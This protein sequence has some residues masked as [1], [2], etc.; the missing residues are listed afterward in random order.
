M[1]SIKA[2]VKGSALAL[3]TL[4]SGLS[5]ADGYE[6]PVNSWLADSPWP[7]SHRTSYAQG[8]SPL[9][10]PEEWWQVKPADYTGTSLTNI[11]LA[12]SPRYP[13]GQQVYWGST[14]GKVYKLA[15]NTR[16]L[17]KYSQI[18][19]P[20][21]PSLDSLRTATSGAYT[22]VDRDNHFYT[23]SG[24]S[25]LVYKDGS[26][27]EARSEIVLDREYLIPASQLRGDI[28]D[29]PIVGMNLTYD[30]YVAF[31]TK[32]GTVGVVDR[33]FSEAHFVQLGDAQ[34]EEI[35]NS[36]ALDEEGGIYVVSAKKMYR[37]QWTGTELTLDESKGGWESDY[38]TG[39]DS[40]GGGRLGAGS[41]STPSLMG[42][43]G[44]DKFV[45][46]TDG[47]PQTHLVLLWRDEIPAD[48][49][50]IAP[51]KS[52]RIAAEVPVNYGDAN[53]TQSEQSV[54]VRG[55]GAVVVSNDYRNVELLSGQS[56]GND[57]I[58]N[59]SNGLTVFLSAR[60]LVQP[61]GVQKFEWN[62]ASRT[63]DSVW[64]RGDISCPNGIPTMSAQSQLFYCIG[65]RHGAWTLEALR[66]H[67]GSSKFYRIIGW[68]NIYN[69][70][71]AATQIGSDGRIVSGTTLGVMELD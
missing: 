41:G 13:D 58:D 5:F 45:V 61:Y 49:Q 29:D 2:V 39:D 25:V 6:P 18:N 64:T 62:P 1:K 30:G 24:S 11:T 66:W 9:R 70:F 46:I 63:L 51:G 36:I 22:F 4:V 60:P 65:A 23:V 17:A 37:V 26:L 28:G 54:M 50:P 40:S 32:Q 27:G 55:Y 10:G 15:A 31:A 42:S 14:F 8:S 3:A 67:D 19:K 57:L 34:G 43:A 52:R 71:Y 44:M 38:E 12:M 16:G 47:Q 35:S 53:R 68:S 56:S 21:G 69:S 7:M 59:L 20:G 33:Y 48:W